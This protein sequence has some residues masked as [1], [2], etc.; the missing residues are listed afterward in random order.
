MYCIINDHWDFWNECVG[1]VTGLKQATMY[2]MEQIKNADIPEKAIAVLE[3][4]TVK[5]L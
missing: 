5:A 2:T 3:I 4:T 1:W